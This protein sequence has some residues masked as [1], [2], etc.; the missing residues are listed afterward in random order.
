MKLNMKKI[1][2]CL[3]LIITLTFTLAVFSIYDALGQIPAGQDIGATEQ[4]GKQLKE[5]GAVTKKL[6]RKEKKEEPEIEEKEPIPIPAEKPLAETEAFI[7]KIYVTGVVVLPDSQ[8]HNIVSPY[9]N[10]KLTL[11]DFREVADLITDAYRQ[12]GYVTSLAYLPPQKIENNILKINVAEGKLGD[13]IIKG[14]KFFS[15]KLLLSY[16]DMQKGDIFNYDILRKDLIDINEHPDRTVKAALSRGTEFSQTN[17]ELEVKE[18]LPIHV[19]LGYDNY[20]SS[21]LE[22]NRYSIRLQHTNLLG[23]D[24]IATGD[25]YLGEC[26]RYQLYAGGY[27]L[28]V[29]SDL[30]LGLNYNRVDQKLGKELGDLSVKGRGNILSFFLTYGLIDTD[31]FSLGINT[32]FDYKKIRNYILGTRTSRDDVR[33]AKLGCDIDIL[34]PFKGRTIITNEL[35]Y[36]IKDIFNGLKKKDS[37]SSRAGAGGTFVKDVVNVARIQDLPASMKLLLEGSFQFTPYNLVS[38]EQFQIGGADNVRG[39]PRS[40][41]VGDRGYNV[42]GEL[43]MPAYFIPKNLKIPFAKATYYDSIKLVGFYDWGRVSYKT[44]QPGEKKHEELKAAGFGLRFSIPQ[45]VSVSF[46]YGFALGQKASDGAKSRGWIEAK[47][48]F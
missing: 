34:D 25:I 6:I 8:I 42:S 10:K 20:N 27:L 38:A 14:N 17:V 40:E 21:Y 9:E 45:K 36:G 24:D 44:A 3:T 33:V 35:S 31:N 41:Y 39:Y 48:Y 23:F 5:K 29:S 18:R 30:K 37:T 47:I 15:S 4:A 16:V 2:T 11:R 19:T 13:I 46:D 26:G 43:Y 22:K 1:H 32:G 7:K 12:K 28:P